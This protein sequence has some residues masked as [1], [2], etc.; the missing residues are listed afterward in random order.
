MERLK[1]ELDVDLGEWGLTLW[2]WTILL[3]SNSSSLNQ[4]SSEEDSSTKLALEC[5]TSSLVTN[6]APF[7]D[8]ALISGKP[9][10]TYLP[11]EQ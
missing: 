6:P 9:Q 1:V 10:K 8:F 4:D 3:V 11:P 7:T 2:H 5:I